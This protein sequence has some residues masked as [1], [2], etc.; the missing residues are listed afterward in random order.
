MFAQA[1]SSLTW[2]LQVCYSWWVIAT[3][4]ILGRAHWI[5]QAKLSEFIL[6]CQ[7]TEKGGI[8]DRP[9]DVADVWHTVFGLTG[10][11]LMGYP[12]LAAVDPIYCL[13]ASVTRALPRPE[14]VER[15]EQQ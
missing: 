8:A 3:L 12:G 5:S 9:E 15:V 10:L 13:P 14:A 11:S 6:S 7:D 1:A 4:S 2:Q